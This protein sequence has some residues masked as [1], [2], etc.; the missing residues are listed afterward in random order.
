MNDLVIPAAFVGTALGFVG[1]L[2]SRAVSGIDSKLER[3]DSKMDLMA[4]ADAE[5]MA[6][7]VE[8]GVR[9]GTAEREIEGMRSHLSDFGGFLSSMGFKKRDGI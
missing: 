3:L 1:W 7:L 4:K 9:I 8:H 6:K 2:L 5:T